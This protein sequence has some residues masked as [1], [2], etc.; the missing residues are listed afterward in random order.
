MCGCRGH[1]SARVRQRPPRAARPARR[2]P[3]LG[4]PPLHT[5]RADRVVAPPSEP[6]RPADGGRGLLDPAVQPSVVELGPSLHRRA[7]LRPDPG[8]AVP[9]RLPGLPHRPS[10]AAGGTSARGR[11]VLRGRGPPVREGA[12]RRGRPGQPSGS[13]DGSVAGDHNRARPAGDPGRASAWLESAC[14]WTATAGHSARCG[15]RSL[16]WSIPSRSDL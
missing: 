12:A 4:R 8:G 7:H 2:P 13:D 1:N 15:A 9:A 10:G 11:R 3:R 6:L 16:C 5:R 14:S